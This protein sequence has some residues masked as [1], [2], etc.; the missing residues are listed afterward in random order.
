MILIP[1][2]NILNINK[3]VVVKRK[4]QP[5]TLSRNIFPL[6]LECLDC[7]GG[8]NCQYYYGVHVKSINQLLKNYHIYDVESFYPRTCMFFHW[9]KSILFIPRECIKVIHNKDSHINFLCLILSIRHL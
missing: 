5:Y 1:T 3:L 9:L 4:N 2:N 6:S 7:F 8:K